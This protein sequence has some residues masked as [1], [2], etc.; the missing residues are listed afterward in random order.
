M[1]LD[2]LGGWMKTKK[3]YVLFSVIIVVVMLLTACGTK[4]TT[5]TVSETSGVVVENV[6]PTTDPNKPPE[7][8]AANQASWTSPK[9]SMPLVCV[10]QGDFTMGSNDKKAY[11]D[12]KPIHKVT[13]DAF[14]MD[15]YE[16]SNAQ[17][18][19]CVADGECDNPALMDSSTHS[20]Y[21]TDPTYE[22]YPVVNMSWNN[23][24]A[25]CKWAGRELPT[26]AQWEKAARGTGG[27]TYPWGNADP[28]CNHANFM[29]CEGTDVIAVDSHP[30]GVS[31]FGAYN[32]V[33]NVMEWVSDFYDA[34]IYEQFIN[35]TNPEVTS[36]GPHVLRG[37]SFGLPK[38]RMRVST[39]KSAQ[40]GFYDFNT[41]FR[42]AMPAE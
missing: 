36:G 3:L 1:L 21:F 15:M 4:K 9:D 39:R 12:E 41:G 29:G 33:G 30:D 11:D 27:D 23:A 38:E 37:G 10:P 20:Y 22:N 26:E 34:K 24:V 42:C 32:M 19:E 28:T 8:T 14:W 2:I 7:C 31:P 40:A 35:A 6:Q 16:V 17:Y 13:L 25:Y 18:A 5:E